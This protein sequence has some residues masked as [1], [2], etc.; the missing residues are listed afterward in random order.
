MNWPARLHYPQDRLYSIKM[1]ADTSRKELYKANSRYWTEIVRGYVVAFHIDKLNLRNV[2]DMKAGY[3]GYVKASCVFDPFRQTY[4][5]RGFFFYV[6]FAA[7]LL[8]FNV[9]CWVMNVVPVSG[10][11]TLPVIYDRGLVGVMH[12]WYEPEYTRLFTVV[13]LY[14]NNLVV[15]RCRCEPFYT[16]PRTYDLIN[17]AGLFSVEQKRYIS[18]F[19]PFLVLYMIL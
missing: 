17:A 11:N 14:E 15:E 9:N 6:R 13:F 10:L 16:Y 1:D 19:I 3:G 5:N 4:F 7:A 8:D 12:D 2:M 18:R